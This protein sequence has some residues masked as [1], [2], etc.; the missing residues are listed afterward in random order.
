ML[1]PKNAYLT[2]KDHKHNF[3][4]S[5]PCRLINP[6]KSELGVISKQLLDR[7]NVE[8]LKAT[9][10]NQWKSTKSVIK[11]FEGITPQRNTTFLT[12][13]IKSFYPNISK[14]LLQNAIKFAKRYTTISQ[15]EEDIIFQA[16]STLLFQDG[17][18]WQK[19]HSVDPFDV[20]MGSA[21]GAETCELIGTYI[22]NQINA[23]IPNHEIGLYRDDGLAI[24]HK[25]ARDAEN[26]KKELC[27]KFQD[28]G[29]EITAET[30][31]TT[32]DF[33]D[34]TLDVKTKEYR[35]FTKPGNRHLY[36]HKLSNQ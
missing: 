26:T 34:V 29:L 1:A 33:L 11:W 16:K 7:I 36:V 3:R 22:L 5:L 23:I 31:T 35:P 6:C 17:V 8:L 24:I 32:I 12:F 30:N 13:D 27:R 19:K 18:V 20:T 15:L 4:E 14:E 10:V 21:D 9:C 25:N 28:F 2:L